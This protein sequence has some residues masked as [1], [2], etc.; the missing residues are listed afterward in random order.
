M[1][2]HSFDVRGMT[3]GC[4]GRMPRPLNKLGYYTKALPA[5]HAQARP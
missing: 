1:Q 3:C 5:Q 4:P 2:T